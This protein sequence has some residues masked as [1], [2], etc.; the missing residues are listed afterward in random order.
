MKVRRGLSYFIESLIGKPALVGVC[1]GFSG[2]RTEHILAHLDMSMLHIV[3]PFVPY[4]EVTEERMHDLEEWKNT[5]ITRYA[6]LPNVNSIL[7]QS[8]K[9]GRLFKK[10]TLDFVYIDGSHI[11]DDVK[12]DIETWFPKLKEGGFFGGHDYMLD[13]VSKAVD[14]FA[15]KKNL[16][17]VNSDRMEWSYAVL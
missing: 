9:A 4:A 7:L 15:M 8:K 14:E 16:A 13:S 12:T 10:A 1:V 6:G 17:I 11:Y 2:I 3:D 5:L